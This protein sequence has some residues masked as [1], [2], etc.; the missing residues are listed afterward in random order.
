MKSLKIR[1]GVIVFCALCVFGLLLLSGCASQE[2]TEP[3]SADENDFE[4]YSVWSDRSKAE[5]ERF[6]K[7]V[8][9]TILEKDWEALSGFCLYPVSV[10]GNAIET[11]EDF[12]AAMNSAEISDEFF[13]QVEKESCEEMASNY[14]G[15]MFGNGEVWISCSISDPEAEQYDMGVITLN[16]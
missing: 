11:P 2:D 8:R 5:V 1:S 3:P 16:F 12:I 9:K 14:Q 10:S 15:C 7:E 13:E 4:F 6:A